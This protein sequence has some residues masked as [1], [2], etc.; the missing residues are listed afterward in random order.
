[1]EAWP[2]CW[3]SQGILNEQELSPVHGSDTGQLD[4]TTVPY[5]FSVDY[6]DHYRDNVKRSALGLAL[7]KY[8][9]KGS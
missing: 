5:A 9:R 8:L 3:L 4:S 1:M 6:R 2:H 7:S